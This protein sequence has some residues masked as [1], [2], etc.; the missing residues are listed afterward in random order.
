MQQTCK[1]TTAWTRA[2]GVFSKFC[3]CTEALRP[4]SWAAA[5]CNATFVKST[6]A[7][8][9]GI[10]GFTFLKART[11]VQMLKGPGEGL[12]PRGTPGRR[13]PRARGRPRDHERELPPRPTPPRVLC[14]ASSSPVSSSCLIFL[15]FPQK[16]VAM[17]IYFAPTSPV[18]ALQVLRDP[19]VF[20]T[21]AASGWVWGPWQR[22]PPTPTPPRALGPPHSLGQEGWLTLA[23]FL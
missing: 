13:E 22:S 16:Y 19:Y 3:T 23:L 14:V 21:G 17:H 9:M 18:N 6:V 7:I 4:K 11:P 15:G 5:V 1:D 12:L 8:L 2:S 20:R 10:L